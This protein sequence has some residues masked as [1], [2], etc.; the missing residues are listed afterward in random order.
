MTRILEK[1][2]SELDCQ[3]KTDTTSE[4]NN[5]GKG[6]IKSTVRR[7]DVRDT[8][9]QALDDMDLRIPETVQKAVVNFMETVDVGHNMSFMKNS[10]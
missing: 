8:V 7:S 4:R 2:A 1:G 9:D 5:V 6:R 10:L 3:V